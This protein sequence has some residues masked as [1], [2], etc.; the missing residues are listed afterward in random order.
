M[1]FRGGTWRLCRV[2]GWRQDRERTWW[3][4]LRWGVS[5]ELHEDWYLFDGEK[6]RETGRPDR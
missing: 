6:V 3:C 1:Q 5:G 2:M 4:L